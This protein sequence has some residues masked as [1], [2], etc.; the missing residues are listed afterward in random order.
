MEPVLD[1]H[2]LALADADQAVQVGGGE[3]GHSRLQRP[4][5]LGPIRPSAYAGSRYTRS[6]AAFSSAKVASSC[7]F[8]E[9]T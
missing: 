2:Q 3:V 4:D 5:A 9:V 6:Q 7:L 1:L 8:L